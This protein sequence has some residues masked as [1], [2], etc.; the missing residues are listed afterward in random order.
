MLVHRN[1]KSRTHILDKEWDGFL[2][3]DDEHQELVARKIIKFSETSRYKALVTADAQHSA[4]KSFAKQHGVKLYYL[5]YNPVELPWSVNSPVEQFP[6]IEKNEVG[7]RVVPMSL[8]DQNVTG[9]Q[10]N[11]SPSYKD[12]KDAAKDRLEGGDVDAGWKLEYFVN[13]L[14]IEGSTGMID[15]TPNFEVMISLLNQKSSPISSAISI[16]FDLVE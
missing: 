6:K 10:S 13:D 2:V 4:M 3:T 8:L 14:F 5:F 12:I 9:P 1:I 7:C 11:R 16:T 15:D